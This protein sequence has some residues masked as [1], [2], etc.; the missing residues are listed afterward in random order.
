MIVIE[1]G[2]VF[3]E[4]V[5]EDGGKVTEY[6]EQEYSLEVIEEELSSSE[7]LKTLKL[8]IL[9][10]KHTGEYE[11]L[12]TPVKL[13]A[14]GEEIGIYDPVDGIVEI[15]V[16]VEDGINLTVETEINEISVYGGVSDGI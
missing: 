3:E 5:F 4:T 2:K 15:T 7:E 11:E 6:V 10:K 1:N 13:L 14:D 8:N 16:E 12:T 9:L